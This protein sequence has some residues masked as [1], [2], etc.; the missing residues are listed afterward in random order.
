MKAR[1]VIALALAL[2]LALAL[3]SGCGGSS[4]ASTPASTASSSAS[5]ASASSGSSTTTEDKPVTLKFSMNTAD[6]SM[7][8]LQYKAFKELVE[9][10]S[11][12]SVTVEIYAAGSLVDDAGALDAVMDGTCDMAHG[13]VA[14]MDGMIKDLTPLEIPGY[15]SG[16]DFTAFC[17]A[18]NDVLGRI[19]ADYDVKFIG[20]NFQGQSA[21]VAVDAAIATPDMLKGQAVRAAGTY[22]AKA[23][24]AWGGAP[25]TV[26]LADLTTALERKTV[27]SAYTGISIVG[28]FKLYEMAPHVT[29]TTITESYAALI[30]NMD[31]WTSLSPSQQAAIERAAERWKSETFRVGMEFREQYA[32][33]IRDAGVELVELDPAATKAFTDL[34]AP[35]FTEIEG[36]LGEKGAE[37]L[38]TLRS[39]NG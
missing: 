2:V 8:G 10:E 20:S 23:V 26:S 32:K 27:N 39:L 34:T 37:L 30:M 31:K 18:T 36:S 16:S 12:G 15:Y 3:L 11:G 17:D 4:S 22:I 21:F 7:T 25:T 9:E 13:M 5:S 14:Y 33:E 29:F 24:E 35:I 38:S 28:G 1:N 19:F 6:T